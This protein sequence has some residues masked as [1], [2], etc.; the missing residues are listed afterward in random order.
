MADPKYENLPGIAYDQPDVYES[1][2]LPEADQQ[3]E[4]SEEENECIEKMNISV[5]DSFQKFKG[6]Q[7]I[8]S[9][10]FSDRISR[11]IRTGYKC[12]EWELAANGEVETPLQRLQRLKC[13][14]TD[15]LEELVDLQKK[16]PDE[17][18]A[19]LKEMASQVESTKHILDEMHFEEGGETDPGSEKLKKLLDQA[20]ESSSKGTAA[21]TVIKLRPDV[22]NL[23]QT[24]RLAQLEHR[25]HKLESAVGPIP[26]K[27]ERVAGSLSV[28]NNKGLISTANMLASRMALL[29]PSQLDAAEQRLARLL[30]AME[31]LRSALPND[32]ERDQ[33]ISE[34]Y[35]MVKK[36]EGISHTQILERM[37]ALE[38]LHKQA[39]DFGR[40]VNE[41]QALQ[42]TI[43]ASVQNNK[44]LLQG[45]QEI[46]ANNLDHI[47]KEIKKLDE[48]ISSLTK[49]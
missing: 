36:T 4:N 45:V 49:K 10:D 7:V 26:D 12:G 16:G 9:V 30:P 29:Q 15:L 42:N 22:N 27:M 11:K 8:G 33:K 39:S 41:L 6:K 24:T 47:Q 17:E 38:A 31:A 18:K 37:Q 44:T 1:G 13:E 23:V 2:D 20:S 5:S 25:L 48:R 40:S 3:D 14:T 28:A 32:P 21:T 19:S 35:D 43:T 46:F 34:L